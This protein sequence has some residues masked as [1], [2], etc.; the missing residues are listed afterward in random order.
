VAG[1]NTFGKNTGNLV[2]NISNFGADL[3]QFFDVE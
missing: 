1:I 2:D 3:E